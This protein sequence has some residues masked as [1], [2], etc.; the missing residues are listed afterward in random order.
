VKTQLLLGNEKMFMK[1]YIAP[2][3][4][5]LLRIAPEHNTSEKEIRWA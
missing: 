1:I 5:L 3:K 2:L 4:M